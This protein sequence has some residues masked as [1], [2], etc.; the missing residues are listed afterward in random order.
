[1]TVVFV[2]TGVLSGDKLNFSLTPIS[3]GAAVFMGGWGK[4]ILGIAAILAF[5]S[6]ANAG[7]M[8]ASRYPLAL[9]RDGLLPSFLGR[10]TKDSKHPTLRY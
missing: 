1:M 7:I 2:T 5:V 4:I 6:T 8:S 10:L 9:G 3:D